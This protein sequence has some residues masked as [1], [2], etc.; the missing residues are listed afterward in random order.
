MLLGNCVIEL[1]VWR[2]T[3]EMRYRIVGVACLGKCVTELWVRRVTGELRYRIVVE[4]C[5]WGTAL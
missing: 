3:G 5:Y 4:A 2:V 1:W